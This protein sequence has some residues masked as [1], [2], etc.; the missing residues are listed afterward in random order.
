MNNKKS[1]IVQKIEEASVFATANNLPIQNSSSLHEFEAKLKNPEF[2]SVAID[3]LADQPEIRAT[4]GNQPKMLKKVLTK[5]MERDMISHFSWTGKSTSGKKMS[6]RSL[7]G[8]RDLL[9]KTVNKIDV[10]FTPAIAENYLKTKIL[11]YANDYK[12]EKKN[13]ANNIK[14]EL[15]SFSDDS[16]HVDTDII[17]VENDHSPLF[18]TDIKL[19]SALEQLPLRVS[20]QPVREHSQLIQK[21]VQNDDSIN[22]NYHGLL[23]QHSE[24]LRREKLRSMYVMTAHG[25][26]QQQKSILNANMASRAETMVSLAL[27]K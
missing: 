23:N 25:S 14:V 12:R 8:I 15:I 16:M 17:E 5:I 1:N 19:N 6:F 26:Q 22:R 7:E 13:N 11:R 4:S 20:Y 2:K 3:C 9:Y 24:A 21:R 10:N 27:H 18:S